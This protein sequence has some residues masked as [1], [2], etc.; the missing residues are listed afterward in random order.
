MNKVLLLGGSGFIGSALAE[1]LVKR[2]AFVTVPTRDRERAK[3]LWLLPTCEVVVANVHDHATL[4]E[5]V[6]SHDVV[7]NLLGVLSGDF[8]KVHVEFPNALA[9]LCATHKVK[10]LVQMSA[11]NAAIDAG[12]DYLRSRGRGEAAVWAVAEQSGLDVTVFQPSVVFGERDNFLNMLARLVALFPVIPLGSPNAQFQ[13]VWVEDVARSIAMCI[14]M[15]RAAGQTY[16]LVGPTVFTL[17]ELLD[18]TIALSGK[19]RWVV[20]LPD[21]AAMWQAAAFEFPPGKWLGKLLGVELTRDNVKSMQ[22]PNISAQPFP[23]IFGAAEELTG[24]VLGYRQG[25]CGRARYEQF[26]AGV[27]VDR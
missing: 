3:H 10:R 13:P 17:R 26:R 2:G 4:A 11:L 18:F 14:D 7:I 19:A 8:E 1:A 27:D 22:V 5:L 23:A 9:Q 15:P 20:N 24:V 16:V 21:T 12:S 25:H 6:R